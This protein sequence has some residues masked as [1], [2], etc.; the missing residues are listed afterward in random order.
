MARMPGWI[1]FLAWGAWA[2][3]TLGSPDTLYVAQSIAQSICSWTPA[4]VQGG[5]TDSTKG[6][7]DL[8]LI[9]SFTLHNASLSACHFA[10]RWRICHAWKLVKPA[11]FYCSPQYP[12]KGS[13][14]QLDECLPSARPVVYCADV[15]WSRI[16]LVIEPSLITSPQ[17]C[18]GNAWRHWQTSVAAL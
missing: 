5:F 3:S 4:C 2:Q 8:Y 9:K 17:P 18:G 15:S 1:R 11:F 10:C 12:E 13:T 14:T 6:G 16:T 7:T